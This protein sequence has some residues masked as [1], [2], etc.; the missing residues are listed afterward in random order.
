MLSSLAQHVQT[1]VQRNAVPE[2]EVVTPQQDLSSLEVDLLVDV[3]ER[4]S[5]WWQEHPG[6]FLAVVGLASVVLVCVIVADQ[7]RSCHLL[8]DC[9]AVV[10][11]RAEGADGDR[12]GFGKDIAVDLE[13]GSAGRSWNMTRGCSLEFAVM[14]TVAGSIGGGRWYDWG[15][16]WCWDVAKWCL[17]NVD[18]TSSL[19]HPFPLCTRCILARPESSHVLHGNR[20]PFDTFYA[21]D[22]GLHPTFCVTNTC[23]QDPSR[24][25]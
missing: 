16:R 9:F 8:L 11:L 20:R 15:V 23:Q 10:N 7:A 3:E 12:L 4:G 21:Y 25:M 14:M 18:I 22:N 13:A 19:V 24:A 6:A 17:I 5:A 2:A 1:L